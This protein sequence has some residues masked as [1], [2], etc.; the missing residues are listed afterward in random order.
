MR[1]IDDNVKTQKSGTSLD[2]YL[3]MKD[4]FTFDF[5]RNPYDEATQSRIISEALNNGN[6]GAI[7]KNMMDDPEGGRVSDIYVAFSPEQIKSA[8]GNRGTFDAG[9]RNILFMPA[10]GDKLTAT[11]NLSAEALA[12]ADELGGLPVPSVGITKGRALEG[13]GEVTLLGTR[14]LVD[15]ELGVPAFGSDVYS[16]R[17]PREKYKPVKMKKADD[18]HAKYKPFEDETGGHKLSLIFDA[19]VNHP[20]LGDAKYRF[21]TSEFAKMAFLKDKGKPVRVPKRKEQVDGIVDQQLVDEVNALGEA[22]RS[23]SSPEYKLYSEYLRKAF[24]RREKVIRKFSSDKERYQKL[25][26]KA[27]E[28]LFDENGL[29]RIGVGDRLLYDIDRFNNLVVDKSKL[30]DRIEKKFT[31]KMKAE[32]EKWATQEVASLFDDPY[33]VVDG[34]KVP[35]TL[36]TAT[37]FMKGRIRAV[38]K[39]MT[40]GPGEARSMGSTKI[41]S[42]QMM[43]NMSDSI[44]PKEQFELYKKTV[45]EPI[46]Q[47]FMDSA[48]DSYKYSDSWMALDLSYRALG[49]YLQSFKGSSKQR[50]RSVLRQNDFIPNDSLVEKAIKAAEVLR[51]APTEYF[52]AKPQRAVKL[53]EFAGAI[54][55][56]KANPKVKELADK[57]GWEVKTYDP[58]KPETRQT[59]VKQLANR[60]QKQGKEV[61]F[62]PSDPK[63]PKAQPVNRVKQQARSMPANRFMA[64][65]SMAKGELSERFR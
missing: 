32:Y 46:H 44:V 13:F 1:S 5:K 10:G 8:T 2:V 17:F 42:I 22:V 25:S 41:S 27:L 11:H 35:L 58:N 51:E 49:Q 3:S 57:Y 28:N 43:R 15:P 23:S 12:K 48:M 16:K 34:K 18:F 29:A 38:E 60:L 56:K 47:A 52:E 63:A 37:D 61:L 26:D 20:D 64:P 45:Q 19:L 59:A 24:D 54:I 36:D 14:P 21:M 50:M 39:N 65:A 33:I 6:D 40:F 53:E 4:P 7:F 62:M 30:R 31:K 55:P 9:E